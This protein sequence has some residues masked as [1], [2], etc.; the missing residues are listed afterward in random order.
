M[1]FAIRWDK[2]GAVDGKNYIL[3][4]QIY[5]VD[6]LIIGTLQEGG[7]NAYHRQHALTCKP[8]SKGH[9]VLLCHTDIKKNAPGGCAQKTAGRC[10]T[11]LLQ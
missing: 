11:S 7:I 8:G 1:R 10:H 6:D 2:T 9:S 3:P 4:Q 5:V